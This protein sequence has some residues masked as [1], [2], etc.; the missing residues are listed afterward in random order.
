MRA[1]RPSLPQGLYDPAFEHDACGFGFVVDLKARPSHDIVRKALQVL[2]NLEHRGATGF[3]K[4]TGDGAGLLLQI[5]HGFFAAR[6]RANGFD[7]PSPRAT[8]PSARCSS[9]RTRRA[10]RLVRRLERS[11][12]RRVRWCS[13]ARRPHRQRLARRHGPV[14]SP[15]SARCSSRRARERTGDAFERKL[16]VIRRLAE[17]AVSRSALPGADF[18]V[19]SL[20]S[21]TVYKGMLNA[22][23]LRG[24]YPDLREEALT[25]ASR[26]STR[27]SRPTRSPAGRARTPTATS[28]TTARSTRCA[29]T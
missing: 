1:A 10:A 13:V 23:Q 24:F 19:A 25:S 16:Y 15:Q 20:S 7:L 12:P 14:A 27:A 18:Y 8:T 4:N 2:C 3:E 29:A 5:P 9:R 28:R 22:D 26:W 17:K 6:C 21:R 11:S